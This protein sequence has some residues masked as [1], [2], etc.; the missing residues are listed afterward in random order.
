MRAMQVGLMVPQGWKGEYDR[1][2]PEDAW[3]RSVELAVDAERLG[4]E[5]IWVFDHFHTVPDPTDEITFE[6]FTM[7]AA[8]ANATGRVRLGHM[9]IC[10]GFRN[11]ALTA[12]MASTLDVIS[13][14]RFELGIGAGWKED[15][16][17]A[18]GYG[19][20]PLRE[21]ISALADQLEVITRMLAPGRATFTGDHA[22]V[23]D[24]INEP[25]GLQQPRIPII[26]G[27]NGP[28]R[29][30]GYAVRYADELNLVFLGPDELP[31]RLAAI[32]ERCER[33]GRDPATLR[34]SLYCRDET[35]RDAGQARV[36]LIAS[37][38]DLGLTRLVAFPGRYGPD[39][40]TQG[41]FA[42]DC[43]AAGI[44]LAPV[45]VAASR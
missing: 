17:R 45:E 32:A 25:R 26:V 2:R 42:E 43:R 24:A 44:E 39:V 11:P 41:R 16:W 12:K 8:L 1:W 27:G 38:R 33:E 34:V 4:F 7:L 30:L 22:L 19:F 35:V 9:V 23:R 5:S 10:A 15:E 6:S 36:D 21:R 29:T 13:G 18:Y 14:G 20:P 3:R 40:E 37:F 31:G 28:D